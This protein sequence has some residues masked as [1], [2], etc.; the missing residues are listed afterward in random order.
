VNSGRRGLESRVP[1]LDELRAGVGVRY[2]IGGGRLGRGVAD[3]QLHG[4]ELADTARAARARV[5]SAIRRS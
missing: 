4:R 1:G 3:T 2:I 5:T